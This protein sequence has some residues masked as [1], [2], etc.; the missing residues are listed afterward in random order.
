MQ[1]SP[2]R[3]HFSHS[4]PPARSPSLSDISAGFCRSTYC[5][6]GETKGPSSRD[7]EKRE[8]FPRQGGRASAHFSPSGGSR[9]EGPI[10]A[11]A[12]LDRVA[13]GT[14]TR[15][16]MVLLPLPIVGGRRVLRFRFLMRCRSGSFQVMNRGNCQHCFIQRSAKVDAPGCVNA[17]GK[18]GQKSQ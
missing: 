17:A 7:A 13:P 12:W 15:T 8:I 14:Q 10:A 1:G 4:L 3:S 2:T 5:D 9:R 11:I 16:R 6:G 18:L